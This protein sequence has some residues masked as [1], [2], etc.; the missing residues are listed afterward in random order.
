MARIRK[1]VIPVAGMGTR[2]LP[3]TKAIPKELLPIVDKPVI[4][5]IVEEA[6]QSGIEE[7]IFITNDKKFAI[8]E[9]FSRNEEL[10]RILDEKN[11]PDQL[12]AV[13]EMCDLAKF[14]YVP[15]NEPLGLGHA[16]LQARELIGE[17]PFI[18]FGGDDIVEAEVPAARQLIDVFNKYGGSVL[19]VHAVPRERCDHYGV[20][21]LTEDLGNGINSIDDVIEKPAID[22]APSNLAVG[23]R[24][25]LTS[26]IFT[27][28]ERTKPG[29][30][31][32]IQLTDAIKALMADEQMHSKTYDGIYRDCGNKVEYVKAM[33]SFAIKHEEVGESVRKYIQ[34]IMV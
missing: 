11:K 12:S 1:A 14:V 25:L 31:G 28:L 17:E 15:Q 16:V 30:G 22:E 34:S 24:W 20:V 13:R 21:S 10:E 2:F 9:H 19:G 26:G 27:H 7:I 5:Y 3:A 33:I 18:V 4:Q 32:E 8:Q 29:A 6:I 23:G